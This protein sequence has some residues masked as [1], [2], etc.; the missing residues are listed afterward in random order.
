MHALIKEIRPFGWFIVLL[1]LYFLW[2]F[3]A[4]VN[5]SENSETLGIE[6]IFLVFLLAL[7]NVVLYVIYRV[8]G[9]KRRTCPACGVG[10]KRGVTKC[11]TCHFDF[12]KAVEGKPQ[13]FQIN[14]VKRENSGLK[15]WF[16]RLHPLVQ[17]AIVLAILSASLYVGSWMLAP[18]SQYMDDIHCGLN[19]LIKLKCEFR[20]KS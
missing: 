15:N 20:Y 19:T 14:V 9:D 7:M 16:N 13:D 6:F 2:S 5:A 3:L 10:V 17:I 4:D 1:N 12:I 8:T 18:K 11:P